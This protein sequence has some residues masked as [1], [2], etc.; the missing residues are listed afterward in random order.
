MQ[1]YISDI[2]DRLSDE[3]DAIISAA[4]QVS[5]ESLD[6][7]TTAT[8]EIDITIPDGVDSR[9]FFQV[10]RSS[11][12]Q[13][14]GAGSF[15]DVVPSDEL[16]LVYEAY[17]TPAE[18]AV[19]EVSFVDST[20]DDFRG[21]NL[22][23]NASTGE[24]ILQAND[25]PPF[26]KDINRYRNSI[27]Y[28]NTRTLH[29][30]P[31]NLLGVPR[32]IE[33]YDNGDT[34][35][36]TITD[37]ETT[38]TYSFVVG[39]QEITEIETVADVAGSLNS[40]F[41]YID[42][43]DN[44][45]YVWIN[46]N[47]A[48]VDP[49]IP[50][51]IGIE[52]KVATNATADQVASAV[53]NQLA[54]LLDQFISEVTGDTVTVTCYE[55]GETEDAIDITTGFTITNTQQGVGE[56]VQPEITEIQ[57]IA[58][59]LFVN[60]GT[61][62]YFTLNEPFDQRRYY[63]FFKRGTSTDPALSGRIGIPINI[64]GTET[65]SQVG[66]LIVA[67][68]PSS[69]FT[70][71]N[72][73]GVVTVTTIQYGE[74]TDPT[75]VV[76]DA[77]FTISV[78]QDG[79]LEV[80]LSPQ[81]SP[82]QAVDE[83]ARSFIRVINKNPGETIYASYLSSAF[84]VPGKMLLESRSLG[85]VNEFY[86]LGNNDNT[87]ASF[88]PDIGP[89]GTVTGISAAAQTVITTG[90]NHGL[91]TGDQVVLTAT[92]SIP[93]IDG[94]YTITFLTATSFSIN[95]TVNT[96]GTAGAYIRAANA[97]FSENEERVNRVYYSKF[98]QPDAVPIANFFD[99]GATDM[100]ILRIVPLRDSLFV[101]KQDGL[102]RISGESA[103]FQLEL[104]DNS[105]I[106]TAPDS[107]AVSN[108][109]I[110]AWT[111]QGIQS[112]TEGGSTIIS[113]PIDNILL[114]LQ[115]S[116]YPNFSTATW[117]I[118]YESDNSYIV[119]T[120]KETTDTV[121]QNAY[122]YS[123]LT[124]TWTTYD[125]SSIAGVVNFFDDKLYLA[126][127]DIANV[128]QERKTFSRLDYS[129]REYPS[130]LASDNLIGNRLI[131]PDV[132]QMSVGDV[133]L[134]DQT[135]TTYEFNA[136]LEKLDYD[137]GTADNNYFST[138]EISRGES[139]RNKLVSLAQKLDADTTVALTTY[140]S[141][142]E[143]LTGSITNISATNPTVLTS[144]GHGLLNGRVIQIDT[145]DSDPVIN[146]TYVVTVIDANTFSIPVNVLVAGTTANWQTVDTDFRDL[147]VCYNK[148]IELLNADTGVAF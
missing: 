130:F 131:L 116:N 16:Q 17:P 42:S 67:A 69:R 127:S 3:P 8:V 100:E 74:T 141:S 104:F 75:E 146:G 143:A 45:Y 80:V 110:Y 26:A 15:E 124:N 44:K 128:E 66:D 84:D 9:Y 107:V 13:A 62:D 83:T 78:T 82:A 38:N 47:N 138:L 61:S 71:S 11:V 142:I 21:A 18:L 37:G 115:S 72:N 91:I 90:E 134:Q 52:V 48:G 109:V 148:I 53:N 58:G 28:A 135:I 57:A 139:P 101:F 103:P 97:V 98:L 92:D 10:Y 77:G 14:T 59:S 60:T 51:R 121:A 54:V 35:K 93:S 145:S 126:A 6:I 55:V 5:I 27:F 114:K 144:V 73:A 50:G 22:Y 89:E 118:G 122:R 4:D 40:T 24:G 1:E 85:N 23:T 32:M 112:L 25:I 20:P 56:R 81:V 43:V 133:L 29:R 120:V 68:I 147:K 88:N 30:M 99:V 39:Q 63:F 12:A 2:I 125:K 123:T 65:V 76:S 108:N 96:P 105:F 34:P 79:A 106:V 113:R 102:Y 64:S 87:G 49:A 95:R 129:D 94:L 137:P 36:V 19:Q 119:F 111:T 132:T 86:V 117:G 136:L 70:A 7:T 31:L 46:V 140:E 33:D 41:F